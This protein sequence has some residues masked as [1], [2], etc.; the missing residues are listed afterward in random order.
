MNFLP[1]SESA[2]K[3][4]MAET[5]KCVQVVWNYLVAGLDGVTMIFLVQGTVCATQDLEEKPVTPVPV[6]STASTAQPVSVGDREGA[7]MAL[8]VLDS[9]SVGWAGR[10]IAARTE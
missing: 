6:A 3:T 7:M 8:K 9:V 4:T 10:E 1:G 5:V 2:A